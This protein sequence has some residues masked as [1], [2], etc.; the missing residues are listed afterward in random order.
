MYN[1]L[2]PNNNIDLSITIISIT[3]SF[4][5]LLIFCQHTILWFSDSSFY[6]PLW[7]FLS[8]TYLVQ[9]FLSSHASSLHHVISAGPISCHTIPLIWPHLV[10]KLLSPLH[11]A[12][13]IW[14]HHNVN[15]LFQFNKSSIWA[16]IA[17]PINLAQYLHDP[18]HTLSNLLSYSSNENIYHFV[19]PD[20][21]QVPR[22]VHCLY[23]LCI[24]C[25][26]YIAC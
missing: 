26:F 19:L 15:Y 14:S 3:V 11:C 22:F 9:F 2:L 18:S 25:S 16:F 7:P 5:F 4:Y 6:F 1:L 17:F 8:V 20:D 21:P 12:L 23:I 24:Q 10:S 13:V